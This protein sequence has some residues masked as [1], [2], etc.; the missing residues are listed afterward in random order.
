MGS[1]DGRVVDRL[2]GITMLRKGDK[3][4]FE[5]ADAMFYLSS[6]TIVSLLFNSSR[7]MCESGFLLLPDLA[8]DFTNVTGV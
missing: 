6:L 1:M 3:R 4:A 8:I 7:I 5:G 2:D